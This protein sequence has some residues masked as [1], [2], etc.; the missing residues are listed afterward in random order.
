MKDSALLRAAGRCECTFKEWHGLNA[1]NAFSCPSVEGGEIGIR[2]RPMGVPAAVQHISFVGLRVGRGASAHRNPAFL[3]NAAQKCRGT[4]I[5][6][7]GKLVV[8]LY[9]LIESIARLSAA[10]AASCSASDSVG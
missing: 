8:S 5:G 3:E 9:L 2:G 10:S 7:G 6:R 4:R 1:G